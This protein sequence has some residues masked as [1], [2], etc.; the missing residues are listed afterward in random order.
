MTGH[1]TGEI[2][3]HLIKSNVNQEDYDDEIIRIEEGM[4]TVF[5]PS[6]RPQVHYTAKLQTG[7]IMLLQLNVLCDSK[8]HYLND[9][10]PLPTKNI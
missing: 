9:N 8:N 3:G 4:Q 1:A 5:D 10:E 7:W 2:I 6:E